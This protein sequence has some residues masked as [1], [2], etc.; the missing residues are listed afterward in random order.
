MDFKSMFRETTSRR[1]LRASIWDRSSLAVDSDQDLVSLRCRAQ[2]RAWSRVTAAAS[3]FS[4]AA[5]T[6]SGGLA[7][8]SLSLSLGMNE[9]PD[10][11][12]SNVI[13]APR[14]YADC[15]I[16]QIRGDKTFGSGLS[17]PFVRRRR[18]RCIGGIGPR[19]R[20]CR[21]LATIVCRR[22]VAG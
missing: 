20:D 15:P 13:V 11:E 9:T 19:R 7:T 5:S 17:G 1:K 2:L 4:T 6:A 8:T 10:L 21:A 18:S 14:L 3:S 22:H 16:P 12:D